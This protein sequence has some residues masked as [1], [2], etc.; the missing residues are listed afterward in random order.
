MHKL[1]RQITNAYDAVC[2]EDLNMQGMS[3]SLNLGK[4]VCDNGWDVHSASELQAC[5]ARKA[6]NQN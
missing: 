5:G 4:S 1:S 2:I 6:T 3:Q